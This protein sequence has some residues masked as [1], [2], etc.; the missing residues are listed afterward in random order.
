MKPHKEKYC[1][2]TSIVSLRSVLRTCF[3]VQLEQRY[4]VVE[5]LRVVVVVDV[6]GGHADSLGAWRAKLLREV[7]VADPD[8]YRVTSS[9][10]AG[11]TYAHLRNHLWMNKPKSGVGSRCTEWLPK[12]KGNNGQNMP[13]VQTPTL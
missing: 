10:D 12:V 8:V 3:A 6:G 9:D 7:V 5:G 13:Y 1:T 4:I 2:C 11:I